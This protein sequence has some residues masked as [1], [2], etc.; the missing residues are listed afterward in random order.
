LAALVGA[1]NAGAA[2]DTPAERARTR[3]APAERRADDAGAAAE[4]RA[5]W[6]VLPVVSYA[7]ETSLQLGGFLM[8]YFRL[9]AGSHPTTLSAL[10]S[11][12]LKRQVIVEL[13]PVLNFAHNDYRLEAHLEVQRYPDRFFGVGNAVRDEDAEEYERRFVRLR[14]NFR[15]RVAGDFYAG[16]TTDQLVMG[17]E[18]DDPEG[19][20]VTGE[21]VGEPGGFSSGLGMAAAFDSRDDHSFTTSGAFIE[22]KFLPYLRAWGSEYTFSRTLLDAR[23]FLPTRARHAL[24]IRYVIEVTLGDTPFYQLASF[25]GPNSMRGY[26]QGKYRDRM[27]QTLEAEY[28]ARLF[29]RFGGA[30]FAG[31]GQVGPHFG[32]MTSATLRPSVGGG[33]RFDLSGDDGFNLR[34]DAGGWSDE[35]GFYVAV[36]EAF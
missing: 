28:R 10:A 29:W 24:G 2:N 22:A 3:D 6:I 9:D 12:T 21:Y 36:L 17:I 7:P 14:T 15:R 33:V 23:Y 31:A 19:L 32:A 1:T 27:A 25:G 30:L 26:F 11:A 8:H 5:G 34:V 35:F 20:F 4:Q 16:L 13:L 18:T